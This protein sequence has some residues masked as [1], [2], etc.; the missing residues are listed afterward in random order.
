MPSPSTS[1]ADLSDPSVSAS[2][3]TTAAL[4]RFDSIVR[5]ALGG[6]AHAEAAGMAAKTPW[7]KW[8]SDDV[9]SWLTMIVVFG[10]V[11]L[12]LLIL[13]LLLGMLLL[14]FS[15]SKYQKVMTRQQGTARERGHSVHRGNSPLASKVEKEKWF[16][17]EKERES[18]DTGGRRV[19][20]WGTIEVDDEKRKIIYQDDAEGLRKVRD[21]E[22]ANEK[23]AK[24]GSQARDEDF[25]RIR[26]YDMV[27][28][29][30]W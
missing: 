28:K 17:K 3:T 8:T 1:L 12:V 14:T 25:E 29:R 18:L 13:K 15:R 19:G 5:K 30:I 16:E 10:G 21:R 9:I 26:R 20:G 6:L 4:E 27:A 24:G 22:K 11:W 7:W 2:A 23:A